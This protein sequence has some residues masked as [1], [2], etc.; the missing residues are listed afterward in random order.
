MGSVEQDSEET[1]TWETRKISEEGGQA[2]NGEL[3]GGGDV[4]GRGSQR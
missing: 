3:S 1:P 2:E 4:I